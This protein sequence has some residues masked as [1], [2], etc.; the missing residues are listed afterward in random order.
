LI[1]DEKLEPTKRSKR[2]KEK[3]NCYYRINHELIST[4]N[5]LPLPLTKEEE[6]AR[7]GAESLQKLERAKEIGIKAYLALGRSK[8]D[9]ESEFHKRTVGPA[10]WA[11]ADEANIIEEK[12]SFIVGPTKPKSQQKR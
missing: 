8:E 6:L 7:I 2:N 10:L 4:L 5:D 9:F 12:I 1:K 11:D 3:E